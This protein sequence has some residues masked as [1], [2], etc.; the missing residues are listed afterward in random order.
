MTQKPWLR[1]NP[2]WPTNVIGMHLTFRWGDLFGAERLRYEA[3]IKAIDIVPRGR[4]NATRLA[5]A[6]TLMICYATIVALGL[7]RALDL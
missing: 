7:L 3:Q 2:R 6:D 1:R 5:H 4:A